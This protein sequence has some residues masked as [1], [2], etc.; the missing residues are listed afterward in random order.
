[1]AKLTLSSITNLQNETSAVATLDAN[2][3]LVE[4]SV[5]N[6]LSRDGTSP[7]EMGADLDMNS[8]RILNLPDALS[9]QEPLTL[10]Q[11]EAS[12]SGTGT[13]PN[14][15]SYLTLANSSSLT[16]ERVL[17]A[18]SNITLTDGGAGSTVTIAV[19]PTITPSALT[20][21]D[22]TNVTLTLG[23]TPTTALLQPTSVTA[24]WTGTLAASR[25]GFG[26][27]VSASSGVPLFATGT[28][29]FTSTSGTGNF[30]R[31]T[32][33]VMV[34][35]T[36]GVAAA[37]SL[38]VTD[39]SY[40]A[41]SWNGSTA[42][43]TKNAVRDKIQ[44]ITDGSGVYSVINYG[45]VGDGVTNS[46][47]AIQAAVD[48]AKAVGGIVHF[49]PG[50]F[51]VD[52]L[53]CSS[54][55]LGLGL[56]GSGPSTQGT[57]LISSG[58]NSIGKI[59]L[60]FT[61]TLQPIVKDI[62]IVPGSDATN[63]TKIGIL[64]APSGTSG[65]IDISTIDNV[66]I[67]GFCTSAT[68][69]GY[70]LSNAAW[71]KLSSWNYLDDTNSLAL[72]LTRVNAQGISSTFATIGAGDQGGSQISTYNCEFHHHKQAGGATS[73]ATVYLGGIVRF[74]MY[75]GFV[76]GSNAS[77]LISIQTE[78]AITCRQIITSGI[79]FATENGTAPGSVMGMDGNLVGWDNNQCHKDAGVA[80]T[81]GAGT[82]T[83]YACTGPDC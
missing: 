64:F 28:P 82:R 59:F 46:T 13:A 67:G 50:V 14:T 35:P 17:T 48:A 20:K 23:G 61:G 72:C 2:N 6:T 76:A 80:W 34:T 68:V 47:T 83:F 40:D 31:V 24:G 8:N 19:T 32:S 38:T 16:S 60:D 54:G 66:L 56:V 25:G 65:G 27:S 21:G 70:G 52:Q 5:E 79:D 77:R 78:N 33:P 7:N 49:P 4:A 62:R 73:N 51:V 71:K 63:T 1:M 3:V 30:L 58:S 37:T 44:N 29:T 22:D 36:L 43:P 81:S 39:D 75:G 42:V 15:A 26:T 18:G 74:Q 53:N 57:R 10:S 9:A 12:V 41:T 69:Y 11:Y 55:S 45:A